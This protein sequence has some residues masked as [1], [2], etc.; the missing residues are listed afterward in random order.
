[1]E[2]LPLASDDQVRRLAA[3]ILSRE[4]YARWRPLAKLDVWHQIQEWL[5]RYTH[6]TAH[7]WKTRPLLYAAILGGLLV[8]AVV[9]LLHTVWVLRAALAAARAPAAAPRDTQAT[10]FVE[11][12]DALA[13]AG[14][15][16]EAAHRVQLAVIAQL[17]DRG[18][19]ELAR[20]EPNRTLRRRLQ[21][22][23]LPRE[24]CSELLSLLNRFETHWFRDGAEDPA[25]Y[26]DWRN[27]HELLAGARAA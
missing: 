17:L 10:H 2:P 24:Q 20:S 6:W 27:F 26:D 25:L 18:V 19:V 9:L 14:R 7:L 8:L 5:E 4:Q 21:S 1:M 22:A 16:L 11:E 23:P 3:E 13:A 12:A 15:F